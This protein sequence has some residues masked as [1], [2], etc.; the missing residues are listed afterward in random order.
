MN[1]AFLSAVLKGKWAIDPQ[2][3]LS[4]LPMLENILA[5]QIEMTAE[6]EQ[7]P[8]VAMHVDAATGVRRSYSWNEA[9][10]GS[11]AIV[12]VYGSLMKH[13]A[14]CGPVGMNTLGE[15]IKKANSLPNISAIVLDIDSPGGTVD[16]TSDF[17]SIVKNS[18]KPV[19]AFV[20]GLAASAALWVA[21]SAREVIAN[22]Q[23]AEIGSVGV[24]MSFWDV[25]PAMEREGYRFHQIVSSLSDDKVKEFNDLRAGK[26]ENYRKYILDPLAVEFQNV[27][28]AN[29]PNVTDE[30]LTGKVFFARDVMGILVDAIGTLESAIS[31]AAELA[32]VEPVS[33]PTPKQ[34]Q[35]AKQTNPNHTMIT[36]KLNAALGVTLES[37]D[38]VISLNAEQV[39]TVEAVLAQGETA[40]TERDQAQAAL[41]T[42]TGERDQANASLATVTGERDQAKT[43]LATAQARIAELEALVPGAAPVVHKAT[44]ETIEAETGEDAELKAFETDDMNARVAYL[45]K[46]RKQ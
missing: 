18:A 19:V 41:N 36:T 12:S 3:A 44:T 15:R 27:I 25:I 42:V 4:A 7:K 9:P 33:K 6:N 22:D 40:S 10:D 23:F 37:V 2:F 34:K 26:Y 35:S 1:Y 14:E 46:T 45:R 28:R 29:R 11:V 13:D 30:H 39:E 38:G 43:D 17:A 5:G 31:R 20:N 32:S 21:S 24:L 16:G 8:L